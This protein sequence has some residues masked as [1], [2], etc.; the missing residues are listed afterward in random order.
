MK[1][2]HIISGLRGGGAEHAVLELCRRSLHDKDV[3][4]SVVSLSAADDISF[5]FRQAGIIVS[6]AS[7]DKSS[8]RAINAFKGFTMLLKHPSNIFHAHMF[9]ACIV[10]CFVKFFRPRVKIIFTLHN[11]HVPQL[12]RQLLMFIFRPLRRADIIFPGMRVK[13][14]QKKH[15]IMI[16]N[17]VDTTAFLHLQETKPAIFTC[18]FIGRLSQEKNPLFLVELAMSLLPEHNF[19]IRVAGDGPL[20]NE[21][22]RRVAHHDLHKH[23]IIHGHVH[24]TS[25]MLSQCH[26]L[27]IPSLW[28]GMPL[29]MLEAGA[30]GIPVIAT[31]VGNIPSILN[32]NNAFVGDISNFNKLVIDV[33]ENY[34]NALL[35][36]RQ[37]M[38]IVIEEYDIEQSYARH[39]KVYWQ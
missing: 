5:K 8:K 19:I 24:D 29:V 4:M 34:G 36:A 12:H 15:T 7:S 21:L 38:K 23:F 32:N 6:S 17:A 9:H 16:P 39:M 13:W 25:L 18:A 37:L 11:N 22:I 30:S 14:F 3:D 26:C 35:K 31:A 33:M 10:A 2:V 1:V 28:E 20:K 27:L